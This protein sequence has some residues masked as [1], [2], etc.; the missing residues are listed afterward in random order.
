MGYTSQITVKDDVV[1]K[2]VMRCLE[3]NVVHR[4][5]GWLSL[6]V[7]EPRTPV[8]LDQKLNVIMM[9]NVGV[10]LNRNN[11]PSDLCRQLDDILLMLNRYMCS[12]NDINP[13]N[14]M[15][16][17]GYVSLIDFQWAL[18]SWENVPLAWPRS[19]NRSYRPSE[20]VWD[21]KYSVDKVL[22]EMM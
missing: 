10:P 13:D 17:N 22:E 6:L 19:L 9:T 2:K 12:H 7:D 15:V 20:I 1:T 16:K 11:A 8:L 21:D 18:P 5:A 3:H 4:E 14:L